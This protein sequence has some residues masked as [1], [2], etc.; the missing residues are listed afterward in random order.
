MAIKAK[1]VKRP[2]LNDNE[3]TIKKRKRVSFSK[4]VESST[5]KLAK[6]EE[7]LPTSEPKKGILKKKVLR[8]NAN[9]CLKIK[10]NASNDLE[11]DHKLETDL[12]TFGEERTMSVRKKRLQPS[13]PLNNKFR[14]K[15]VIKVKQSTKEMLMK[16]TKKERREFIRKLEEKNKPNFE[17]L[18]NAKLLWETIRSTKVSKEKRN[19]CVSELMQLCKGKFSSLAY[20]HATS[21]VIQCLLKL[22][23]LEIRNQIFDE[24][25]EEIVKLALSQ[26]GKYFVMKM[27]KYGSKEQRNQVINSLKGNY[28]RLY[29]TL[30]S[31]TLVNEIYSEWG[32]SI[33]HKQLVSEF[34]GPEFA[35]FQDLSNNHSLLS[36]DQIAE[37]SPEKLASI[38]TN[39][40]KILDSAVQKVPMLK[41]SITH[42]LLF[43][44]LRFCSTEQRDS[45]IE[46]LKDFLP[47][48]CHTHEG[49]SAALLCLWNSNVNQ[50]ESI[51]KSFTGLAISASKD[52]FVQRVLFGIFDCVDDT[53]LVN[54]IIIKPI[55]DN[56]ADLIYDKHGVVV[57][58]YLVHPRDP[59]VIAKSLKNILQQGDSNPHSK[60]DASS[61]YF[62][63]FECI[64]PALLTFIKFNMRE[65]I[66]N[67]ISAVLILDTLAV[68]SSIS[69]FNRQ[70]DS[71]ELSDCLK[72]IALIAT[73][74]FIPHCVD[75]ERPFHIIAG[76]CARFVFRKLLKND[77][78]RE[79][80]DENVKLSFHL[81]KVL[82]KENIQ[83]WTG[84]DCG[85]YTLLE[86]LESGSNY[87]RKTLKKV[88]GEDNNLKNSSLQGAKKLLDELNKTNDKDDEESLEE[89][90]EINSNG[91]RKGQ[92]AFFFQNFTFQQ[93]VAVKSSI[94]SNFSS[95]FFKI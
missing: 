11:D 51:V 2:L 4:V 13:K 25:K 8:S 77:K 7:S 33:Q 34:Y 10:K 32:N 47:E 28:V 38:L 12:N 37:Q 35:I 80:E 50:R 45:I 57:L 17:L 82:K 40:E 86:I 83:S 66:T 67:K 20:S 22:K 6:E 54:K 68:N 79:D 24:L 90:E 14:H 69:P 81:M 85:C 3:N 63:L 64:K 91:K 36:I 73:D 71:T 78:L 21:R 75:K 48:I 55:A 84:M 88:L 1:G 18:R 23:N 70:L 92:D 19:H 30:F 41:L 52:N 61:R 39:L 46:S 43:D 44:F 56:I 60:L 74:E 29:K 93:I 16:M 87:A 9:G 65:M 42:K 76:G 15:K 59:H 49:S 95:K 62:N 53:N 58:H 31:A 26:Y 27:L 94:L 72:E 89:I 5:E